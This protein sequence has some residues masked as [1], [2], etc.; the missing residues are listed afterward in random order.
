MCLP[1][2]LHGS[3]CMTRLVPEWAIWEHV[4]MHILAGPTEE[5][6]RPG[7]PPKAFPHT[8]PPYSSSQV[9]AGGLNGFAKKFRRTL[10]GR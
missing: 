6:E 10:G 9:E 4:H 3:H 1:T 5:G 7:C 8:A 2:Y